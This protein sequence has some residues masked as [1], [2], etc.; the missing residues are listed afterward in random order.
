MPVP[1]RPFYPL[2]G[3]AFG[4]RFPFLNLPRPIF[5]TMAAP[6][7]SASLFCPRGA[8]VLPTSQRLGPLT[9][10]NCLTQSTFDLVGIVFSFS[11]ARERPNSP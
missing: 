10:K 9:A 3:S 7:T 6:I 4:R 11:F 2:S 1:Y 8:V 5:A